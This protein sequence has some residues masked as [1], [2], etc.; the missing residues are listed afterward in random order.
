[1]SILKTEHPDYTEQKDKW[2]Y[3]WEQYSGEAFELESIFTDTARANAK[4]SVRGKIRYYLHQKVQAETDTAYEERLRHA[5]PELLF[6]TAVDSLN[7]ILASKSDETEREWG[8]FGD[9]ED[10]DSIAYN[11]LHNA[12][13]K[14]TN[15]K[16]LM[17][18]TGI[19]QSVM[20]RVWGL[21]DGISEVDGITIDAS[22]KVI[23]PLSV[24]N[25][26]PSEGMPTQVLVKEKKDIRT[27]ITDLNG[28]DQETYVLYTLDGWT[29]FK[30]TDAGEE[31]VDSGEYT[32]YSTKRRDRRIL[33]IFYV[34]IPMPRQLGYMLA[35]KQNSIFNDS[36]ILDFGMRNTSFAFMQ[37]VGTQDQYEAALEEIKKG[38]RIMR[39][40]PDATKEHGYKSPPSDH[41]DI[42]SK[43]I[44]EKRKIF[45]ESAFRSYGDAARQVTATEI[46]QES[47]SGVEA[48]L[49]LLVSSI[50]EFENNCFW[51]L[52]QVYFPEDTSKWGE[53]YVKRSDNFQPED[54][55]AVLEQRSNIVRNADSAGAM[56]LERMVE[57]LNPTFTEDQVEEEVKRIKEQRGVP[58][59]GGA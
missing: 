51:L 11:L 33:P 40:E 14:G 9:P 27:D 44:E 30:L 56:S 37:F 45:M 34:D 54:V 43:R 23:N 25:W 47:R 19:K 52:E 48:F 28:A 36:S 38:F 49:T 18:Q 21:V 55:N 6:A 3:A 46:R 58:P 22:V 29:R 8:G 1:M 7:G 35:Q 15:W 39:L 2:R 5:D 50:D 41:F 16:P 31:I 42:V 32:Y 53:A 59:V 12:D 10:P 57:T 24:I 13:G 20:H 17:K 4:K 26:F